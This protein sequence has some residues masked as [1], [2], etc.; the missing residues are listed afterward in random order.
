MTPSVNQNTAPPPGN[1]PRN[2]QTYILLGVAVLIVA[3]V[4]FS[5]PG[6]SPPGTAV[7]K[8]AAVSSPTK[9]EIEQYGKQLQAEEARLRRAQAE[10]DR[11]RSAFEQQVGSAPP[12][13]GMAANDARPVSQPAESAKSTFEQEK[14]RREYTSLFASN[15]ALSLPAHSSAAPGA[16]ETPLHPHALWQSAFGQAADIRIV[17]RQHHR[18][19]ADQPAEWIVHRPGELPG[20]DGCVVAG[21]PAPADSA[22]DAHP[23]RGAAGRGAGSGTTRNYVSPPDHAGRICGRFDEAARARISRERRRWAIR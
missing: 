1:L 4:V 11:A 14:E 15:V 17:R 6:A 22:G 2:R 18:N 7:P 9:S 13:P 8:Q 16:Q 21:S 5:T 20:D 23:G 12:M 3:A 10:A 19:R